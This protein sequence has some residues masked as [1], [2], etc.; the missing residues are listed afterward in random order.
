MRRL[1]SHCVIVATCGMYAAIEGSA[2]S[3]CCSIRSR[4]PLIRRDDSNFWP[5]IVT[6]CLTVTSANEVETRD[7]MTRYEGMERK[8]FFMVTPV[9]QGLPDELDALSRN[10]HPKS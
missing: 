6:R 5:D 10:L 1:R 4:A 3:I 9:K 8:I 7:S 2:I